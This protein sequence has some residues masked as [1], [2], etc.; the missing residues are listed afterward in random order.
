MMDEKTLK[1][2]Y[3]K[4]LGYSSGWR[5]I[6]YTW[7][8]VALYALGVGANENENIYYYEKYIKTLPSF[9][10]IPYFN[11]LNNEPQ[12]PQ[13]CPSFLEV[14]K[15]LE[16]IYGKKIDAL[17]FD[18]E[19][20]MHRPIDAIKG[21]FVFRDAITSFY[22]RGDKG[23]VIG[24]TCPV[25]DEA[26]RLL[27]ENKATAAIFAGGNFGGQAFPKSSVAFPNTPPDVVFDDYVSKVQHALYRLSGDTNII[28]I[29]EEVAK[30]AGMKGI[31]MQGFCLMGF[32][33]RLA[34]RGVIPNAPEKMTRI[35][36]QFR[37]VCYP[38]TK[39]EFNGWVIKDGLMYFKLLNKETKE[40]ILE[41]GEF[42]WK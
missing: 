13:P 1:E 17:D 20:I 8:D 28:H 32:A 24:T 23:V 33:C 34:I 10:L 7:R 18:H 39:L 22:D 37:H 11:A 42:E 19:L 2:L 21:T 30:A 6:E 26:G 15:Q 41:R 40:P 5:K 3:D 29:D 12:Q 38:D 31:F 36:A 25:Y 16:K 27:C 4:F 14:W 9:G 35:K